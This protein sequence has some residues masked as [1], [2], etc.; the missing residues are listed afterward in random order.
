MMTEIVE[1][2]YTCVKVTFRRKLAALWQKGHTCAYAKDTK[3]NF[4]TGLEM[5]PA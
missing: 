3:Y 5:A 4:Q 2:K 1:E